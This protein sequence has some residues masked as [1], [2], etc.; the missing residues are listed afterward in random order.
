M[1]LREN[2]GVRPLHAPGLRL[3]GGGDLRYLRGGGDL[4]GKGVV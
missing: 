2:W 1:V 3:G 4:V